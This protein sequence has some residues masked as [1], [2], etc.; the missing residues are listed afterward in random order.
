MK[1]N[2]ALLLCVVL[3]LSCT[4]LAACGKQDLSNSKYVGTWKAVSTSLLSAEAAADEVFEKD[5]VI[6]LKGDG[7]GEI[8]SG[9]E[10]SSFTWKEIDGGVKTDGDM[11]LTLKENGDYL[12]TSIIG[13]HILF[14]KQ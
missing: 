7:T 14:E 3:L 13:L 11:K 9:D 12:E 6:V 8:F 10:S 1:K 2:L 5:F 4:A